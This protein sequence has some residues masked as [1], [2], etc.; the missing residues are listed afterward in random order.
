MKKNIFKIL[1][2]V[3]MGCLTTSCVL[4]AGIEHRQLPYAVFVQWLAQVS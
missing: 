1:M 2:F 3:F 4:P